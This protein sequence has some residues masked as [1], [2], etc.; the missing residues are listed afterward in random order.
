[1][2]LAQ[3]LEKLRINVLLRETVDD[4]LIAHV[5]P[6]EQENCLYP[7]P[8]PTHEAGQTAAT[9][10]AKTDAAAPV[11]PAANS[12]TGANSTSDGDAAGGKIRPDR[13]PVD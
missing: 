12:V 4:K 8:T 13:A 7:D 11:A 2:K 1:M 3:G 10:A 6:V 5:L 9:A